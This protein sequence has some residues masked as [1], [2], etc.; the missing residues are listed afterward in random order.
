MAELVWKMHERFASSS[1]LYHDPITYCIPYD[2]L[3]R[4]AFQ[5]T[6]NMFD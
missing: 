6:E 2:L 4:S 3:V 5:Y 1:D